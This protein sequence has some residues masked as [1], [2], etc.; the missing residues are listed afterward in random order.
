MPPGFNCSVITGVRGSS[1]SARILATTMSY[2]PYPTCA[3]TALSVMI[4]PISI[5]KR[6]GSML[7]AAQFSA[8]ASTAHWSRSV[9]TAWPAPNISARIDRMPL[10]VPTSRS[11]AP[12]VM[13]LRSC[14]TQSWV[15]SCI[16]VPKAVPGSMCSTVLSRSSTF[17]S[18]QEGITRISSI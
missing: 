3:C 8:T 12:G 17:T 15:V 14:L 1:T 4:L 18:S 10:P 2:C 6:A 16:P 7:L 11:L 5:S 13:Y 9:P